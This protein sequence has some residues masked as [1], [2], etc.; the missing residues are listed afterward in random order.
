M[1]LTVSMPTDSLYT[2]RILVSLALVEV[3]S[4]CNT[5]HWLDPRQCPLEQHSQL[6]LQQSGARIRQEFPLIPAC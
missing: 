1:F 4:Y 2:Y 5:S 3:G 6:H